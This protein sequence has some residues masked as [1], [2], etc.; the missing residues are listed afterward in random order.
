MKSSDIERSHSGLI[1]IRKLLDRQ[2]TQEQNVKN[3]VKFLLELVKQ[4]NYPQLQLE[5]IKIVC[6]FRHLF[7]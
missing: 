7:S 2:Q 1:G 5:A 6:N 4:Q 3:E